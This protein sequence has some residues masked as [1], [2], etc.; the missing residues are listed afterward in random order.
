MCRL[1]L[2]QFFYSFYIVA[3]V[4][5]YTKVS[6]Q[7]VIGGDT[8]DQS[9]IL[10]LQDTARGIL[11]S[12]LTTAQRD[13]VVQPAFGL[14]ILNTTKKCLETNI[15]SPD[16]PN[17]KCLTTGIPEIS[18]VDTMHWNRKLNITDTTSMLESYVKKAHMATLGGIEGVYS[19]EYP[20]GLSKD[21]IFITNE[22]F[23]YVVPIGKNLYI[24]S[25]SGGTYSA[26]SIGGVEYHSEGSGHVFG[27]GTIIDSFSFN[28]PPL[29]FNQGVTGFLTKKSDKVIPVHFPLNETSLT[30]TVPDGK[31]LVIKTGAGQAAPLCVSN[32]KIHK[33]GE[34]VVMLKEK[35][36][37]RHCNALALGQTAFGYTG[38]LIDK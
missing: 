19:L 13:A 28:L 25:S 5:S 16:M 11:L 12:R 23:P 24:T 14:L 33:P 15:G 17:W 26:F 7:T 18:E 30:Y 34:G 29:G 1:L 9:A 38:Y 4:F 10:D 32:V 31:I 21:I 22:D 36:L 2:P 6:A 8:I 37:V 35:T 3:A 20:D 27:E